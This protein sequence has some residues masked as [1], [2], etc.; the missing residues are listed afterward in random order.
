VKNLSLVKNS[1]NMKNK[2]TW[3]AFTNNERAMSIDKMK[4]V[5]SKSDAYITHFNMFS[6]LAM[7]LTLEIEEKNIFAL[8]QGLTE[9]F[10]ISKL[11]GDFRDNHSTKEWFVYIHLSF[12]KGKGEMKMVIPD[13][14]G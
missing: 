11:V 8:H 6:D 10:S 14:P 2:L 4:S 13:V 1:L 9:V 12:S 3:S 7:S 5:I